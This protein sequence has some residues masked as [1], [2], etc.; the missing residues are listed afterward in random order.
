MHMHVLMHARTHES[1]CDIIQVVELDLCWNEH[2]LAEF[3]EELRAKH[4]VERVD[5]L[6]NNAGAGVADDPLLKA[7]KENLMNFYEV[8]TVG[9]IMLSQVRQP[10]AWAHTQ[11]VHR[12]SRVHARAD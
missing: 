4:G 10:R 9:P 11:T 1:Q 6:V 8:N 2:R 3:V 7:S 12:R 5:L